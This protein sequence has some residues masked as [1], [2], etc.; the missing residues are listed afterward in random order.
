MVLMEPGHL[1]GSWPKII[2][3][4]VTRLAAVLGIALDRTGSKRRIE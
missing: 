4:D 1:S 2:T 3:L